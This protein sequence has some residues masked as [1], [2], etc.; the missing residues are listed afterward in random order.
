M[1]E[2]EFTRQPLKLLESYLCKRV[3]LVE[4]NI[5]LNSQLCFC[6]SEIQLASCTTVMIASYYK[7]CNIHLRTWKIHTY[8]LVKSTRSWREMGETETEEEENDYLMVM[9]DWT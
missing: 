5:N 3:W 1:E 4:I 2:I 9:N 8:F 7:Y 6:P